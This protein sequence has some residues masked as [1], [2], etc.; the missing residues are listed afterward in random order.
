MPFTVSAEN[1]NPIA[2]L[3]VDIIDLDI[4]DDFVQIRVS[5]LT[6]QLRSPRNTV[7]P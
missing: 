4:N 5:I 1:F 6:D 3:F 2:N 7:M